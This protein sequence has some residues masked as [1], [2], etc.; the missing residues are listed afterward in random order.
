KPSAAAPAKIEKTAQR[1]AAGSGQLLAS[2]PPAKRQTQEAPVAGS[3]VDS[4]DLS[5]YPAV[6]PK[7]EEDS[8]KQSPGVV[9]YG[10]LLATGPRDKPYVA[11]TFDD[12][13]GLSTRQILHLLAFYRAK[14]TFFMLGDSLD[15]YAELA[16]EV[17]R[18]GHL[19][20]NHTWSHTNF[21]NVFDPEKL[22]SEIIKTYAA[23]QLLTGKKT[24]LLRIPYGVSKKWALQSAAKAEHLVVNWT[25]G[26]DTRLEKT[27]EEMYDEYQANLRPGAIFLFHDGGRHKPKTI[28]V[29]EKLLEECRRRGL[30]PVTL[31]KMFAIEPER[32]PRPAVVSPA[33]KTPAYAGRAI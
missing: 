16:R 22:E 4:Q 14:A 5:A 32:F 8:D 27:K 30:K 11:F 19:V 21:Y 28:W 31:D 33:G 20:A 26:V 10:K 25:Y 3:A 6:P 17:A 2:L 13:P 18:D 15:S 9:A 12:G 23:I 24:Y 7:D 29:V 1:S